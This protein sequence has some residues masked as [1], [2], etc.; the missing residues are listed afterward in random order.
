MIKILLIVVLITLYQCTCIGPTSA[1]NY[2]AQT[3]VLEE[4]VFSNEVDPDF[5]LYSCS[6]A[7]KTD[8]TFLIQFNPDQKIKK[9]A[10]PPKCSSIDIKFYIFF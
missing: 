4:E 1:P 6:S 8:K 2:A 10:I 5:C 9:I 7:C 3:T